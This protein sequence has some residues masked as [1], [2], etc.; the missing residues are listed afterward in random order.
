[1]KNNGRH[2]SKINYDC[3]K[4]DSYQFHLEQ[5]RVDSHQRPYIH[6]HKQRYTANSFRRVRKTAKG[7]R[8]T[9][10]DVEADVKSATE[11]DQG[12]N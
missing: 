9:K 11:K 6:Q 1:M 4:A 10:S 12:D 3:T 7:F 8:N 5:K 2:D